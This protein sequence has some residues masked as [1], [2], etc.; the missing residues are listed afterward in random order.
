MRK[1]LFVVAFVI[2]VACAGF[3]QN[4]S[5]PAPASAGKPATASPELAEARKLSEQAAGLHNKKMYDEAL[6]LAKQALALREKA[7]GPDHELIAT[8][9]NNIA[10]IY[11]AKALYSSAEPLYRRSLA[12]LEKRFGAQ[13]KY[14]TETLE[15]LA[16]MRFAQ[17]DNDEAEKFYLRAL[18]IKER[19]FGPEQ[20][21]TAQTLSLM[22]S[23]YARVKEPAK[24]A[25]LYKRSLAIREKA[26]GPNHIE[27]VE[28][29]DRCA[30][31]LILNERVDEGTQYQE[32]ANRIR[33]LPE[34]DPVKQGAVLQGS[35]IR[36]VEP[37]YPFE[38]KHAR[39]SGSVVV[40][41]T[42]DECGRVMNARVLTGPAELT[43]AAVSAA[44]EWRFTPTKL[45]GRPVK[46][47]GTIT[48]KFNL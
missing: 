45:G 14:L 38:A 46:V 24:A 39:V 4:P 32:R 18:A 7:V 36:K 35:A 2:T 11:V 8:S 30:C 42:V 10:A 28:T 6:P 1:L 29:L 13:S 17:S 44:R 33:N 43:G 19:A 48:F 34:N 25:E 47:I 20:L 26:L 3:G 41:V 5:E 40:E 15:L 37:P 16:K 27:L 12:I 31:V 21:E 23:F 9:L 22:G